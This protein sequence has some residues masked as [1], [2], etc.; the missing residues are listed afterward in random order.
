MQKLSRNVELKIVPIGNS[1]GVRLPKTIIDK[2]AIKD[3]VVLEERQEG[4]LLRS[5]TDKR[6][7][8][9]ETFKE[10]AHEHEDWSDLDVTLTDGLNQGDKW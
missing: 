2:Y 10:M 3:S 9:E 1:R 8:W 6:L 5:K 7:S 4:L